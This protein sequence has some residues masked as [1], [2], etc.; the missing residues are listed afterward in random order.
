MASSLNKTPK[1]DHD[2]IS[3]FEIKTEEIYEEGH[4]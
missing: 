4:S 2:Y 3:P 1:K